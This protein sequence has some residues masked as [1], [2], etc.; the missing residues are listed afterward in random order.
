VV[1]AVV[2]IYLY[3]FLVYRIFLSLIPLETG[4]L[5]PGSR[6]EFA[7]QVNILFYLMIFNSLIR[8]HF[9]PIPLLRLVYLALGARLGRDTY[10][11][12]AILDPPL[13]VIG[14]RCIV[15]H[16]A[17]LFAHAIEGSHFALYPI[18]IGNNVTIGGMAIIMPD[19]VIEDEAIVSAGAVVTKGTHIGAGEIWGGVPARRLKLRRNN[20]LV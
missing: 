4:E 6:A 16:D 3:A 1:A 17:V 10:S 12:G 14:D 9:L 15:G 20:T 19:V 13:T 5:K 7:A 11:A 8:T 18:R 2:L